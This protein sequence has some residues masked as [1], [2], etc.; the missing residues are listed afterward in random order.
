MTVQSFGTHYITLH[1]TWSTIIC[2]RRCGGWNHLELNSDIMTRILNARCVV[3]LVAVEF[4]GV[5][6]LLIHDPNVNISR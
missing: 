1:W 5:H 3:M 4:T 6:V 2:D